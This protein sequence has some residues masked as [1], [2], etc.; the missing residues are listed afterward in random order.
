ML[1]RF[2][3]VVDPDQQDAVSEPE[4]DVLIVPVFQL[5]DRSLGTLIPFEFDDQGRQ[6]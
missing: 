1:L 4:W 6:G 2:S 3:I 5:A